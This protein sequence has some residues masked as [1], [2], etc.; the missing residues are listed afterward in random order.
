[1]T[2]LRRLVANRELGKAEPELRALAAK[3]EFASARES[4]E[5]RLKDFALA[6]SFEQDGLKALGASKGE[7]ALPEELAQKWKTSTVKVTGY[8]PARGLSVNAGG[9]SFDTPGFNAPANLVAESA[10][11]KGRELAAALYL[12]LRGQLWEARALL[13]GLA[14]VDRFRV[15]SWLTLTQDTSAES[16]ATPGGERTPQAAPAP[17][18]PPKEFSQFKLSKLRYTEKDDLNV[19]IEREFG[20]GY[21]LADWN[22][23]LQYKDRIA[24]FADA[25]GLVENQDVL[26]SR[27]G[28]RLLGTRRHYILARHNHSRPSGWLV[29]DTIDGNLVDLGL[30]YGLS[31]PVLVIRATPVPERPRNVAP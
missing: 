2:E 19:A 7:M 31:A 29:H 27:N 22:D 17:P 26:I 24:A 3:A 10:G 1:M 28:Q 30:G 16:G 25:V 6:A 13:P 11:K 14:E 8:D 20:P 18:A 21:R 5:A 12:L 9:A 23:V 4:L 15:Q